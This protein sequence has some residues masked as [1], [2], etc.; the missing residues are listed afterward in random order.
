MKLPGMPVCTFDQPFWQKSMIVK[1]K[2]N[3]PNVLMLCNVH[4]QMSFLG[5]IGYV[6]QQTQALKRVTFPYM[7]ISL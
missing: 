7:E 4:I 1:N 5:S 2:M 3:I 6:K